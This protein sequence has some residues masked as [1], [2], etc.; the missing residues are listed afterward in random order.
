MKPRSRFSNP[1]LSTP[2]GIVAL[3]G[4]IDASELLDSYRYGV[5]P[6]PIE[7]LPLTWFCPPLRGIL[8]FKNLHFSRSFERFQRKTSLSVTFD[9]AFQEVIQ[10][11]ATTIR[12]Q[13]EEASSWITPELLA[14]YIELHKLGHAHSV[15]VWDSEHKL[16]GGLYGVDLYGV[17]SAESMFRL[18]PNASKLALHALV[19]QLKKTG[20]TWIDVQALNPFTESLGAHEIPRSKYLDRLAHTPHMKRWPS[21]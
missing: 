13:E 6:W 17:F 9:T 1:S 15:E 7:G 11:C 4:P 10:L 19:E 5:F 20:T 16:V 12:A 14:A 21:N 2:E 3:G 8:E 18:T